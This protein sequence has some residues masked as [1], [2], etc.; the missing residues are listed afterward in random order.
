MIQPAPQRLYLFQLSTSDVPVGAGRILPMVAA[1]YL[2]QMSDGRNILVDSGMPADYQGPAGMPAAENQKNVLEHLAEIGLTPDLIHI[3]I[4]THFDVDHAGYHDS[5]PQAEFIVQRSHYELAKAGDARFAEARAHWDHPAL[6][7]RLVEGDVEMLPGLWVIESS[8]HAPGHQS[9]LVYLPDTGPVLL[10][11][12]AVI[13]E[14]LFTV[15]RPA[16][17]DE[18]S[19]E[20]VRATTRKLLDLVASEQV[21]LIVFGHDGEQWKTLKKSPEFYG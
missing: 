8:G 6:K 2:V 16:L 18:G 10:V 13:L 14:R 17:P 5:F 3:V 7:Y 19:A 12:D 9:V 11:I 20:E 21:N 15:E 4:A 1:C